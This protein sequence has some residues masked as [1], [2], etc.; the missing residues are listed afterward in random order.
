MRQHV[1]VVTKLI[2]KEGDDW[3]YVH[4][5]D[6][7]VGGAGI[8]IV[9]TY[10][11]GFTLPDDVENLVVTGTGAWAHGNSLDNLIAGGAGTAAE[12]ATFMFVPAPAAS[13]GR[14]T[15]GLTATTSSS[16]STVLERAV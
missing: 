12:G 2:G 8:D 15:P 14:S 13:F 16:R 1:S 7:V 11:S 4:P 9:I 10:W 3:F 6:T 5:G